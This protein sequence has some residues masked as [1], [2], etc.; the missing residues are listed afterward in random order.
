MESKKIIWNDNILTDNYEMSFVNEDGVLPNRISLINRDDDVNDPAEKW[1]FD[2]VSQQY[3]DQQ[4]QTQDTRLDNIEQINTEQ[5]TRL[6]NIEQVN[7]EQNTRLE[8]IEQLNTLQEGRLDVIER[9]NGEQTARI[10]TH[11]ERLNNI[12]GLNGTQ[13]GR[14]TDAEGNITQLQ[15]DVRNINT[16]INTHVSKLCEYRTTKDI[17]LDTGLYLVTANLVFR[18]T[19]TTHQ[20]IPMRGVLSVREEH[21][22]KK[23]YG[24]L[25]NSDELNGTFADCRAT[26]VDSNVNLSTLTTI[27]ENAQYSTLDIVDLEYIKLD[28]LTNPNAIMIRANNMYTST[29]LEQSVVEWIRHITGYHTQHGRTTRDVVLN[30]HWQ[31]GEFFVGVHNYVKSGTVTI[32]SIGELAKM[33]VKMKWEFPQDY[34]RTEDRALVIGVIQKNEY[35]GV[36]N[37]CIGNVYISTYDFENKASV[38]GQGHVHGNRLQTHPTFKIENNTLLMM[39]PDYTD[40]NPS[41]QFTMDVEIEFLTNTHGLE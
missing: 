40:W 9:I 8:N 5:N 13:N 31:Y 14:L 11:E 6:D 15:T 12:D 41:E 26:I 27:A 38:P 24:T 25:H 4:N 37:E 28:T 30:G 16:E 10:D 20:S 33:L 2:F 39:I 3:V 21:G 19:N 34:R 22:E 18:R 32:R 23:L 17:T 36:F 1:R 35:L 29:Q 7:T